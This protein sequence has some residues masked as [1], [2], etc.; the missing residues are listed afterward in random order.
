MASHRNNNDKSDKKN[1]NRNRHRRERELQRAVEERNREIRDLQ[2][3]LETAQASLT[4][5]TQGADDR[6]PRPRGSAGDGFS[7]QAEMGLLDNIARYRSIQRTVRD[8]IGR[9]GLDYHSIW[10]QQPKAVIG[11]VYRVARGR[12]PYLRRFVNDW[13]TEEM[14]KQYLRNRRAYARRQG[15]ADENNVEVP[16]QVDDDDGVPMDGVDGQGED[17]DEEMDDNHGEGPSGSQHDD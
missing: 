7:L 10:R 15:F 1:R 5:H 11:K 8:L 12:Q 9:A 13:A 14:V 6:V 4:E 17:N 2:R 16:M 3:K